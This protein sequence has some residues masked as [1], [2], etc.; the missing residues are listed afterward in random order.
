MDEE[1]TEG[2]VIPLAITSLWTLIRPARSKCAKNPPNG[3]NSRIINSKGS[4]PR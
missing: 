4:L 1:S 2:M 3:N